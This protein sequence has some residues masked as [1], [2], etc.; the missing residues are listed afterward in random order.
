[1]G[2]KL[3]VRNDVV[4]KLFFLREENRPLLISFLE[5]VLRPKSPIETVEI[6]N[7]ALPK[8]EVEDK[9]SFLDLVVMLCDRTKIDVEM[10]MGDTAGFRERILYYWAK[11]H[12]E[13]LK[14]GEIYP[15]IA[16]TISICV[17]DYNEFSENTTEF[18]TIFELRET[19]QNF[20]Y[21]SSMQL[22][23]IE[24]PKYD[25]WKKKHQ[26]STDFLN[27]W[28]SFF[29]FSEREETDTNI[30]AMTKDTLMNK[31]LKALE[32]LSQ[33]P[34]A[35]ELAEMREKSRINLQITTGAA[36]HK[37]REEGREEGIEKGREEG[38]E[39][40]REE[41]IEKGRENDIRLMAKKGL[42]SQDIAKFLDIDLDK[43]NKILS[44]K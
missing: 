20:P 25:L 30:I 35:K 38:I 8:A 42:S 43:V 6:L 16:P 12:R 19:K 36:Y 28:V 26:E 27:N 2:K 13:Q 34:E 7:S 17:L 33:D 39:K 14:V 24:L 11:L 4:F 10:Q 18:H 31:A 41:G 15:T 32:K 37:G 44:S 9:A 22:H 29:K 1:M 23:F 40:G 3:N 5:S 21:S